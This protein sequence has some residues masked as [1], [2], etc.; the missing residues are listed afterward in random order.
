MEGGAFQSKSLARLSRSDAIFVFLH[1]TRED[2]VASYKLITEE[3]L[4]ESF[5]HPAYLYFRPDGTEFDS[6]ERMHHMAITAQR[7][8]KVLGKIAKEWGRGL[9]VKEYGKAL[10]S[11]EAAEKLLT[12]ESWEQAEGSLS[13]V[14]RLRAR[15]GVKDRA[16]AVLRTIEARK[17]LLAT[18]RAIEELP[19][20]F[21]G[22]VEQSLKQGDP[23]GALRILR[24]ERSEHEQVVAFEEALLE[25]LRESIRLEPLRFDKVYLSTG[26]LYQLKA[27]W[28]TDLPEFDGLTMQISYRTDRDKTLESYAVYN[29][30]RPY[31][32]HRAAVSLSAR[33]LHYTEVANARVQL[34][35]SDVLLHESLLKEA[36]ADFPREESHLVFGPEL[37]TAAESLSAG[38]RADVRIF[39]VGRY[40]PQR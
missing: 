23:V 29:D 18:W 32:R 39:K 10:A 16:K 40:Q 21:A 14:T 38:A 8:E 20:R 19:T 24:K 1:Q 34:W 28:A 30:V 9:S 36:P 4:E 15:C 22:T 11:I 37:L 6:K 35:L 27:R 25:H 13:A 12:A 31:G 7:V 33:D 17:R 2:S 5:L 26:T 3:Y